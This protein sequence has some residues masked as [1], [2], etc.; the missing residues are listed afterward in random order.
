MK[1][2]EFISPGRSLELEARLKQSESE[3]LS[4]IMSAR[5]GKENIGSARLLLRSEDAG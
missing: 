4:L 5:I 3:S 1:L 2:R